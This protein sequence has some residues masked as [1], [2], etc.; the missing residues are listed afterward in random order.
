MHGCGVPA[1]GSGP[2][3]LDLREQLVGSRRAASASGDIS[4]SAWCS[5][6]DRASF[7]SHRASRGTDGRMVAYLGMPRSD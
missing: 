2:W 5:A 6:H 1:E 3:Q 4:T 7:Y